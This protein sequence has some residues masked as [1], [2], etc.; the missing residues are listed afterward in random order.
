MKPQSITVAHH[1]LQNPLLHGAACVLLALSRALDREG[2]RL[3]GC[4]CHSH[5][6]ESTE[7]SVRQRVARF[8]R[9]S[10]GCVFK[11]RSGSTLAVG[12]VSAMCARVQASVQHGLQRAC[13]VERCSEIQRRLIAMSSA[14][15]SRVVDGLRSK[16]AFWEDLPYLALGIFSNEHGGAEL[17]TAKQVCARCFEIVNNVIAAGNM[18]RLHRVV[19]HLFV[20]DVNPVKDS[21]LEFVESPGPLRTHPLAYIEIRAYAM[22]TLVSRRI[23]ALHA[24]VK[25]F[26][27]SATRMSPPCFNMRLRKA[28]IEKR[29]V[30]GSEFYTFV[31]GMYRKK[32]I[33]RLL[34]SYGVL[35]KGLE[36]TF[37]PRELQMR[38][39][40]WGVRDHFADTSKE[41]VAINVWK[42]CSREGAAP[43]LA[44][45]GDRV[46]LFVAYVK[47]QLNDPTLMFS[48]PA[49]I[50]GG[51]HPG[52]DAD[53]AVPF[54]VACEEP[55]VAD[56]DLVGKLFFSVLN[57]YPEARHCVRGAHSGV[58]ATEVVVRVHNIRQE[59]GVMRAMPADVRTLDVACLAGVV[60]VRQLVAWRI[61]GGDVRVSAS[62]VTQA[63]LSGLAALLPIVADDTAAD[64]QPIFDHPA[65]PQVDVLAQYLVSNNAI[66]GVGE[67]APLPLHGPIDL[68]VDHVRVLAD[69]GIL[70]T[71]LDEF[72]E[73]T[74]A[75]HG[76]ALD[77]GCEHIL[78]QPRQ[79]LHVPLRDPATALSKLSLVAEL[80]RLGWRGAGHDLPPIIGDDCER[81]FEIFML[82]KSRYYFKALLARAEILRAG[83]VRILHGLPAAYYKCLLS[84]D[85]A[86][87][88]RLAARANLRELTND[89]FEAL[90]IGR[91]LPTR[92]PDGAI[93]CDADSDGEVTAGL[94]TLADEPLRLLA[95][96]PVAAAVF[97]IGVEAPPA[98]YSIV[99]C[100]LRINFD[101][102]SHQSGARRGYVTCRQPHHPSC[103]KYRFVKYHENE[104]E[105]A[106]WL[107]AWEE[108]GVGYETKHEHLAAVPSDDEVAGNYALIRAAHG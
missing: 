51:E 64:A 84:R 106:A 45:V 57:A 108:S 56:A 39:W 74:I 48:C 28:E 32:N 75:V 72:G 93:L 36:N 63:Y 1:A 60:V 24:C 77:W 33:M 94:L 73:M 70:E 20:G 49:A 80:V 16:L 55:D 2:S 103:I 19:I 65:R 26:G 85:A 54:V 66:V 9:E 40:R 99:Q 46:R 31:C 25:Y 68:T 4:A 34:L 96:E 23:E 101:G 37:T 87:Y 35:P 44:V 90:L 15:I 61:V 82:N 69:Q 38:L 62:A 102:F 10:R 42:A 43:M 5:I 81:K 58:S 105:C 14:V 17:S 100:G 30:V 8:Q 12:G 50:F 89:A 104:K 41:I 53:W 98:P 78:G 52:V 21:L 91:D 22:T 76:Q 7:G 13:S 83:A 92:D 107:L 27:K 11:G 95:P 18:A 59:A 97:G 29:L 86:V 3:E 67:A 6:L 47:E 88:T 79:V 71:Q